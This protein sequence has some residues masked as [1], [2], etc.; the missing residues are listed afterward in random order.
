MCMEKQKKSGRVLQ[1]IKVSIITPLYHGIKYLN[2][3]SRM[4]E[5]NALQASDIARI[6][7]IISNDSPEENVSELGNICGVEIV[8]LNTDI[9]RGIQGARV[10]GLN[11][12]SGAYILFLDQ[13]DYIAP[14]WIKSQLEH[15]GDAD[16]VVCDCTFDGIPIYDNGKRPSLRECITKEYNISVKH[17]FIPGQVL[18]RKSSIPELW[19]HTWLDNNCCDDYYLWLC[20]YASGCHFVSNHNVLY[21]H[22]MTGNN[23]TLDIYTW[24]A[25]T[26][27]M[28]GIIKKHRL[29]TKEEYATIERARIYEIRTILDDSK[30]LRVK[31]DIYRKLLSC[32]EGKQFD[33]SELKNQNIA[34]YGADLGIHLYYIL[35]KEGVHVSCIIDYMADKLSM[36]VPV[37]TVQNMPGEVQTVIITMLR[38]E[39]RIVATEYIENNYSDVK[40]INLQEIL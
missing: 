20:M 5:D 29:F 30:W 16:A 21:E 27:E 22:I 8:I 28:L 40:V 35:K 37:C 31:H 39:N 15:I 26:Q 23:Q 14:T 18:L 7:W 25:S 19:W 33:I 2:G 3:L 11:V 13:D 4:I 24:I 36:P 1:M 34:I 17:G 10:R 12:S 32:Y 38:P 6:E 9:N